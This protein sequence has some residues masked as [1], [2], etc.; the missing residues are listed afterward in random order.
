MASWDADAL[1]ELRAAAFRRDGAAGFAVLRNRPLA[2]VLQFAGD[3]L[4]DA[5]NQA[6]AGGGRDASG[7]LR[8]DDV[9][10][11]ARK[12]LEALEGRDAAGDD[13]LAD[14]LRDALGAPPRAHPPLREPVPVDLG[15]LAY[16][17]AEGGPVTFLDLRTGD[18]LDEDELHDLH[19][20]AEQDH[21]RRLQAVYAEAAEAAASAD[22][23]MHDFA[24]IEPNTPAPMRDV[25]AYKEVLAGTRLEFAWSLFREERQRGRARRWL[26]DHGLEPAPRRFL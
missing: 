11:L 2:P 12:C 4:A 5:L 19:E 9:E 16:A 1:V 24:D 14:T 17:L 18:L 10:A 21:G 20:H 8:R 22:D 26:A 25:H 15:A 3:L 23:D 6:D 13:L 7:G